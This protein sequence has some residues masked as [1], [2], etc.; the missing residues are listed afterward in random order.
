MK[1]VPIPSLSGAPRLTRRRLL[2]LVGIAAAAL[3]SSLAASCISYVGREPVTPSPPPK[4]VVPPPP[5]S[6]RP[7]PVA[8]PSPSP[9]P[10]PTPI[11]GPSGIFSGSAPLV[12]R[13]SPGASGS[14]RFVT[15]RLTDTLLFVPGNQTVPVGTTVLWVNSSAQ[16]HTITADRSKA[17]D[18]A[19]VELPPGVEPFDA[20]QVAPGQTWSRL[21]D[22]PGQ[23]AYV[24]LNHEAFGM[25]GRIT[26][27]G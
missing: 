16:P 18:P 26:V 9:G 22:V 1:H 8:V 12:S 27:T 23:Y 17:A 21:F 13:P 11:P 25:P 20:G 14:E 24:C 6:A 15:I 10:S 3:A 4:P 2:R 7:S 5:T 19:H